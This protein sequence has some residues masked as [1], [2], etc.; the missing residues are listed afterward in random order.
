VFAYPLLYVIIVLLT[1]NVL[2]PTIS[3][4]LGSNSIATNNSSNY[5]ISNFSSTS[6]SATPNE[7]DNLTS[8]FEITDEIKALIDERIDKNKTNAAIAIGFID[9]NGTQFYSYGRMSN[10]SNAKVDENTVFSI[11]SLTKVFTTT[12]LADMVNKGL[13]NLDDP[14]E[15]YLPS[16]VT[17]PHY[18]V[19]TMATKSLSKI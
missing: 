14:I 15:K 11:A 1:I 2:S 4:V 16:N 9:P 7:K 18:N 12:L 19:P 5:P 8:T 10:T 17:V 3:S 13:I 6:L